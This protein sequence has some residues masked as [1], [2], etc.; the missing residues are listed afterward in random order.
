[1]T[2]DFN[3]Y[4]DVYARERRVQPALLTCLLASLSVDLNCA[5]LEIGCGTGN[6]LRAVCR[7][8]GAAGIGIDPS[9]G[10]L[11]EARQIDDSLRYEEGRA[12]AVPLPDHSVDAMFSVDVVHFIGDLAAYATE[13][14]RVLKPGGRFVTATDSESDIRNRIPLQSH[15]PET[16]DVELARYPSIADQLTALR[17]AGFQDM[18]EVPVRHAYRLTDISAYRARAFSSLRL[19]SDEAFA[20]GISRLERDLAVGPVPA[21]SLYTVITARTPK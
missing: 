5:V 14:K 12:E 20:A 7:E 8:S 10:M 9:P 4:S 2:I 15:F 11:S 17:N 13:A 3:H 19:I 6:Y 1:V 18:A 21:V 16:V